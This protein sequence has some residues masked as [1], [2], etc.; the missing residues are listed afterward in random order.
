MINFHSLL[1]VSEK[2]NHPVYNIWI[3]GYFLDFIKQNI[4]WD[5]VKCF[6]KVQ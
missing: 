4:M 5:T 1:V 3:D 2:V 6:A